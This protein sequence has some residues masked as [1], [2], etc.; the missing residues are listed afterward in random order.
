MAEDKDKLP[1]WLEILGLLVL[2]GIIFYGW[3]ELSRPLKDK[4]RKLLREEGT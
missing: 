3:W 4:I 2:L 1:K